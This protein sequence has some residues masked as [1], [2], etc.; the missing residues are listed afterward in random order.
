MLFL[1]WEK[2]KG[3]TKRLSSSSNKYSNDS[4]HCG[5]L[6]L[7]LQCLKWPSG[8]WGHKYKCFE[9]NDL[10]SSLWCARYSFV[11]LVSEDLLSDE[12]DIGFVASIHLVVDF[13]M[14]FCAV[15]S[16]IG[17]THHQLNSCYGW[18]SRC[19]ENSILD[20]T[21]TGWEELKCCFLSVYTKM[22]SL[23]IGGRNCVLW[24]ILLSSLVKQ[25][26]SGRLIQ[27]TIQPGRLCLSRWNL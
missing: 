4:I 22:S 3:V 18:L 11:E 12:Q 10:R 23:R 25:P 20:G 26:L 2:Q 19:V 24:S 17:I 14:S 13:L 16:S 21:A 8:V 9:V 15:A 6:S 27:W 5:E 1:K 7:L